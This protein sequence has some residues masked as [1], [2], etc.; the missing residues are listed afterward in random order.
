VGRVLENDICIFL[1]DAVWRY[2]PVGRMEKE[3]LLMRPSFLQL[4]L[5][6]AG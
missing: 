1:A 5:L 6:M 3:V 2:T 4:L